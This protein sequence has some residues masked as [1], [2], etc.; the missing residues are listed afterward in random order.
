MNK[1]FK[2]LALLLIFNLFITGCINKHSNNNNE[3]NNNNITQTYSIGDSVTIDK[4]EITLNSVTKKNNFCLINHEDKCFSYN[5]PRNDYYL[6]IDITIKNDSNQNLEISS[7]LN[8]EIKDSNLEKGEY[9]LLSN[10]LIEPIDG[11]I[12]SNESLSGQI[13]YDVKESE[14]YFFYYKTGLMGSK[15]KFEIK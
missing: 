10:K 8:F 9:T 14:K 2:V 11:F 1:K 7:L 12:M 6:I 13:V 15:I 3:N 5:E 4:T